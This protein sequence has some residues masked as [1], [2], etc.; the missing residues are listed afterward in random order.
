[1]CT[2]EYHVAARAIDRYEDIDMSF[3]S[4]RECALLR[5][6]IEACEARDLG[7]FTDAVID[8]DQVPPVPLLRLCLLCCA[9]NHC[10]RARVHCSDPIFL[11]LTWLLCAPFACG[12]ISKLNNWKTTML[13]RIKNG[14]QV[15]CPVEA[16]V[17]GGRGGWLR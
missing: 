9:G 8:F 17:A 7:A 14:V 6:L 4:T 13:L 1:M 3:G 15:G 11:R 5:A 16:G 2:G 12:Q 10:V